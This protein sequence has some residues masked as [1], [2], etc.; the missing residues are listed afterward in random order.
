MVGK[1]IGFDAE[2]VYVCESRYNETAKTIAKIKNW[3]VC[4]PEIVRNNE[5][6]LD[7]YQEPI[8]ANRTC[9]PDEAGPDPSLTVSAK[10]RREDEN[11][12]S[13]NPV[14]STS[15]RRVAIHKPDYSVIFNNIRKMLLIQ[16][17]FRDIKHLRLVR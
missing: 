4:L 6:E 7:L 13:E 14:T 16:H 9:L 5:I 2:H 1:P 10:R 15:K 17:L 3:P 8:V 12:P 11:E